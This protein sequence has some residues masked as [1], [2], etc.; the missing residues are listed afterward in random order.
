MLNVSKAFSS[1]SVNDI[2]K[3]KEFYGKTLAFITVHSNERHAFGAQCVS[4][5]LV[6]EQ[7]S[8]ASTGKNRKNRLR[9]PVSLF[10]SRLAGHPRV[11]G[12]T[13][14]TNASPTQNVANQLPAASGL[15]IVRLTI[16]AMFV[17]VFFENLGKGLYTTAGYANLINYY[18][19]ASHSPAVWKAV[20]GL[21]A[22]H[23]T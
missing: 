11:R 23:A 7:D 6:A 10:P 3:A 2:Q 18:L 14:M 21:A 1:F 22:S 16:G 8:C 19:K 5:R 13:M 4:V 20:M 17:W 9:C 12:F 15:A